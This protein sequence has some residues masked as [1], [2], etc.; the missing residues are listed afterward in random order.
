MGAADRDLGDR[1]TS[2]AETGLHLALLVPL[3]RLLVE[4]GPVQID[5]LAGA[6]GRSIDAVRD[7]LAAMPD[8]EYDEQGRIVGHGLTLRP[9]RHRFTVAGRGLYTWCALDTLMFPT[10]LERPASIESTSPTSGATIR[11][12]VDATG[13]T[14]IDPA[15]AVV[16]LVNPADLTSIRSS[17]CNQVHYFASNADAEPWL[18][19]HRGGGAPGP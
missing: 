10:L 14:S 9:T 7:A 13:V 18:D 1:L 4:V 15:E 11:L 2:T 5:Q 19:R 6:S 12:T 16:S 3:M 8:T 17:F